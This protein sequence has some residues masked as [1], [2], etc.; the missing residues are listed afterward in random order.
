[1]DKER[2][3]KDEAYK[4]L[5]DGA[6]RGGRS[7]SQRK[8]E[9]A[10]RNVAKSSGRPR[11]DCPAP[12]WNEKKKVMR[13]FCWPLE[14][15]HQW[16]DEQNSAGTLEA[17][18]RETE[19]HIEECGGPGSRAMYEQWRDTDFKNLAP[20]M[21]TPISKDVLR[22]LCR[23]RLLGAGQAGETETETGTETVGGFEI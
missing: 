20:G 3:E 5:I 15:E 4:R 23:F 21:V 11:K 22:S 12:G 1:M 13:D 18:E 14:R 16:E 17:S 2:Y 19:E 10:R 6:R 9:A 7:R 8:V